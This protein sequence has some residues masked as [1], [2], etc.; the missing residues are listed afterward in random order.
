[1]PRFFFHLTN[2]K[3]IPDDEATPCRTV[4]EAKVVALAIRSGAGSQQASK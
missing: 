4:D 3:T 1:M 2:G